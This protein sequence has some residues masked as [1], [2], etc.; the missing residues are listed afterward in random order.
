MICSRYVLAVLVLMAAACGAAVNGDGSGGGVSAGGAGSGTGTGGS[1]AGSAGTGGS[2]AYGGW[3]GTGGVAGV[4]GATGAGGAGGSGAMGGF[5]DSGDA[6]V[7]ST[8]QP[9]SQGDVV[10]A[11]EGG[12]SG[13]DGGCGA[14][15]E[16]PQRVIPYSVCPEGLYWCGS[17]QS[18]NDFAC[19]RVCAATG[20][21]MCANG[22]WRLIAVDCRRDCGRDAGLTDVTTE[23]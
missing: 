2:A 23:N 1:A 7:N 15:P 12:E 17:C 5:G 8:T 21:W 22:S 4:G 11:P 3:S 19:A 13:V 9:D 10:L 14:V 18:Q 6:D 16:Y 20:C